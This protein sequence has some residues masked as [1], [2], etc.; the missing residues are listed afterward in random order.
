MDFVS[1]D[2]L[3]ASRDGSSVTP[4]RF[5]TPLRD[6]RAYGPITLARFGEAHW[7]APPPEGELTYGEFELLE[8]TFEP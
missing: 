1:D 2:R 4:Q 8:I 5:S 6:Y 3:R 7:H